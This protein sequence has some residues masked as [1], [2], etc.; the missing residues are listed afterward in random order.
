MTIFVKNSTIAQIKKIAAAMRPIVI[1]RPAC[2][3]S[4]NVGTTIILKK[5]IAV[6]THV[7]I[8]LNNAFLEYVE[9]GRLAT[10]QTISGNNTGAKD[11]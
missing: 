4:N 9:A 1:P 5:P 6:K 7:N 10:I 8:W 2:A 11:A 3:S